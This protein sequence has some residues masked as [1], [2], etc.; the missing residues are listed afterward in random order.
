M[1]K[2]T[3]SEVGNW[4]VIWRQVVSG[5]FVPKIIRIWS[6]VFKL[7][8][9]MLGMFFLETQCIH[10]QLYAHIW[11]NAFSVS[12]HKQ[13]S[14]K[15][16]RSYK[17]IQVVVYSVKMPHGL[18]FSHTLSTLSCDKSKYL[19]KFTSEYQQK[20]TS[21]IIYKSWLTI[22][23]LS[24]RIIKVCWNSNDC[25]LHGCSQV[26]FCNVHRTTNTNFYAT[27]SHYI[28]HGQ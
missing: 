1:Q 7:R 4:T 25:I 18:D 21:S 9:K 19:N 22:S 11:Q 23:N 8:S 10:T 12:N 27:L 5:I 3:L 17:L 13:C 6:L 28:P 14:S 26:I 20:M 15:F 24:L 16:Q 2:H